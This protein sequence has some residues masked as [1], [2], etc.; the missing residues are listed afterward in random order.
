ML[1]SKR[2]LIPVLIAA[3]VLFG[4]ALTVP[5]FASILVAPKRI[6]FEGRARSATIAVVNTSTK[7][8][9][10][11][12][13]W[14]MVEVDE[15]G[16]T[17][18]AEL[19]ESA[20]GVAKMVVFSPRRMTI[21]PNGRQSVR[22][23]LRRP[24]D[25]PPGEYRAHLVFSGQEGEGDDRQ[26]AARKGVALAVKV[27][28]GISIPVI[29]RQ[30]DVGLDTVRIEN[31]KLESKPNGAL[32][33]HLSLAHQPG[34]GASTYGNIRVYTL[35]DGVKTPIGSSSNV[36]LY[37]EQARRDLTIQLQRGVPAGSELYIAYEGGEEYSGRIIAEKKISVTQ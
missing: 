29:V 14:K 36:A 34:D 3:T 30:G 7:A 35:K 25:L 1:F 26:I 32:Q 20:H 10:Y 19:D 2:R 6:V 33:L 22:L 31:A 37:V 24:A 21:E 16:K 12:L 27:N 13:S 9:T 23:S 15:T 18:K 4:F 8:R 11:T 17:K 28:V 5:S